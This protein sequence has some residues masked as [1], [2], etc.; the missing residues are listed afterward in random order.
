MIVETI[1][2]NSD[3]WDKLIDNIENPA[4]PTE[5]LKRL[6]AQTPLA[7]DPETVANVREIF[8]NIPKHNVSD[9]FVD[10]VIKIYD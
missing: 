2:L 3:A 7:V 6:M 1:V 9:G 4:Q 5:E 10:P 8:N